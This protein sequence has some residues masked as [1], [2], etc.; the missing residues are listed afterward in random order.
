MIEFFRRAPRHFTLT[1]ED[2][3]SQS[4]IPDNL[5]VKC[6]QCNELLY[7]KEFEKLLK[8]CQKC[9]YHFRLS[10]RERVAMLLDEGT[11]E[12]A[13]AEIEPA[14]RGANAEAELAAVR[15]GRERPDGESA[16]SPGRCRART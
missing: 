3:A 4:E 7:S 6:P 14:G 9:G 16:G 15:T 11:F 5:W 10:A 1:E 13:D 8:V 2:K 12:E